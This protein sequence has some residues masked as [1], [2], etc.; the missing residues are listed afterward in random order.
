MIQ[1]GQ[2]DQ[3]TQLVNGLSDD[4]YTLYKDLKQGSSVA[5]TTKAEAQFLP[6]YRTIRNLVQQ[7]NTAQATQAVNNLSASDYKLYQSLKKKNIQ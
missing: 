4:D 7:G 1:S 5:S 2:K 6:T 3:A